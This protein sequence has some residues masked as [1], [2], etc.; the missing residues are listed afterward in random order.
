MSLRLIE[1]EKTTLANF[2]DFNLT[3]AFKILAFSKQQRLPLSI[4]NHKKT[5]I[6]DKVIDTLSDLELNT[7]LISLPG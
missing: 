2:P 6:K 4:A 1:N 5:L 7:A 3:D